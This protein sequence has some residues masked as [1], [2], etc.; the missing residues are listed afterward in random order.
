MDSQ[1]Q[2]LAMDVRLVGL[3]ACTTPFAHQMVPFAEPP[4]NATRVP[5]AKERL[6]NEALVGA[7]AA[8]DGRCVAS[9]SG[10]P[11][12]ASYSGNQSSQ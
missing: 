2:P 6:H 5:L 1:L 4:S 8:R 10:A 11:N 9:P 12:G 3:P 7:P